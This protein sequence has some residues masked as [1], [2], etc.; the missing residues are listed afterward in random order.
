MPVTKLKSVPITRLNED[1]IQDF[2]QGFR[3]EL[4]QPGDRKYR[5]AR[6]VFNGM[7]DRHPSLIAYCS[8][9][10][11]VMRAVTFAR[12]QHLEIAIR[13]G[14]HNGGGLG[15]SEGGICID[16]SL[17]KGLRVDPKARTVQV[18]AG[19]TWG[20]VDHATHAFG[21]AM[22]SGI[23]STTGVGGLTLG[24]G[25]GHLT[26]KMG[27]T[28]DNLLEADVVLANGQFVTANEEEHQD[29]FWAIRGGGGN[30]GV[31]TS[32]L[33]KLHPLR[34]VIAGPMFWEMEQA[35]A[36]MQWYRDFILTAPEELNGFFGF[37]TVPPAPP[38]PE[39]LQMKKV[40]GVVW[41]HSGSQEQFDEALRPIREALPPLFEHV[42]EMPY[43]AIQ[44]AFDAL[45]PKGD[46]WYWRGD[47]VKDLTDE[48]IA[49]HIPF[50]E[51]LPSWKSTMHLY[52]INGAV[53]RVGR[54]DTAFSFREA[55]WSMVIVGVDSDPANKEAITEW[56]K[57]YWEALHPYSL[58]GAY[59]NFMM[60]ESPE[61]VKATY[62]D[63]YARLA[64]VKKLY[65][66]SNLFRVNQNIKPLQPGEYPQVDS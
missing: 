8:G 15:M 3:G 12:E 6:K 21:L 36:I 22:P 45:Y 30:F 27:L 53:Q 56:T 43:P 44:S 32:F 57:A 58:G 34:T 20:E 24:G 1:R 25:H 52:P 35:T 31:V 26:R 66:P 18:E 37:L 38:F 39:H 47:F 28:I 33:F 29:L 42:G 10:A 61:R 13:G 19:C 46:Q 41:C 2:K 54:N 55:N 59:V 7:I 14:G 62:R 4:V 5:E 17:M 11:D 49:K 64:H 9:V 16:L 60:E 48:A 51:T 65:D 40:C 23:I 50:G 63:N